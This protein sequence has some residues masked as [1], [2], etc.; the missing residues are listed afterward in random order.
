M[1]ILI[2]RICSLLPFE[3][4][5]GIHGRNLFYF[6]FLIIRNIHHP[7]INAINIINHIKNVEFD[8]IYLLSVS[9]HLSQILSLSISDCSGL[10]L[11]GQL[12]IFA[13][14]LSLS[15]SS[16]KFQIQSLSVSN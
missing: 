16:H 7:N 14:I 8:S 12:S 10:Y 13:N 5:E 4:K 6:S 9:S 2:F 1:L 3:E 11:Y 15:S